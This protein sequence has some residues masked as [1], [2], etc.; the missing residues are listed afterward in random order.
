MHQVGQ[1]TH[2]F[3][4]QV[5]MLAQLATHQAGQEQYIP[6]ADPTQQNVH[7]KGGA[8]ASQPGGPGAPGDPS[9]VDW[10]G[11]FGSLMNPFGGSAASQAL[12]GGGQVT[13]SYTTP[14]GALPEQPPVV[15]HQGQPPGP[16]PGPVPTAQVT[17][18]DGSVH[19]AGYACPPPEGFFSKYWPWLAALGVAVAGGYYLYSK[20]EH[21]HHGASHGKHHGH[22]GSGGM[23]EAI[24]RFHRAYSW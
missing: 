11:V 18:P 21:E 2:P 4:M 23:S 10:Q 13:P 3:L 19:P 7:P 5:G 12:P 1:T 9:G 15:Y 24:A 8:A 20:R 6:T 16:G 22:K 14:G 17:C